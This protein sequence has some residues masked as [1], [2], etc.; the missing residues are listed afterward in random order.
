MRGLRALDIGC[1]AGFYAL[2][3]ARRG[4]SVLAVDVDAHYLRQAAWARDQ[5]GFT[6][7]QI[8]L[9]QL[10]VYELASVPECF[11]VVLFL[12]VLYHLR[13]PMLALDI[14]S[15]RVAIGGTL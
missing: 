15:E 8:E 5:F 13:Y 11:D 4:A 1:N 7:A 14:V 6:P 2:E 10:Q 3:M 12:G 9:R